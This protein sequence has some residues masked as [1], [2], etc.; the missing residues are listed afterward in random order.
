LDK[1]GIAIRGGN[2]CAMPLM[3]VLGVNGLSRVSFSVYNTKDDVD[4]LIE[5][6]KKVQQVFQ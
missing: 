1:Q 4:I 6:I 3:E 5:G 2:H